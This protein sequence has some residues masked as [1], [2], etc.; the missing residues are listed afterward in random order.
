[1]TRPRNKQIND[2]QVKYSLFD[3]NQQMSGQTSYQITGAEYTRILSESIT[4]T[5]E[6]AD[7]DSG[8]YLISSSIEPFSGAG[9]GAGSQFT[10][11]MPSANGGNPM[12]VTFQA[13]DF[14]TLGGST[15]ITASRV[16]WRINQDLAAYVSLTYAAFAVDGAIQIRAA[17]SSGQY[18][19]GSDEYVRLDD[20]TAGI[21]QALGFGAVTTISAYGTDGPTAGIVT[22]TFNDDGGYVT[23]RTRRG[24]PILTYNSG[25]TTGYH[26]A[27]L[28]L[29]PGGSSVYGK[30]THDSSVPAFN[31][32]FYSRIPARATATSFRSDFTSLGP[33][34]TLRISMNVGTVLYNVDVTFN[35]AP[36]TVQDVLDLINN[37]WYAATD[38]P[39]YGGARYAIV[40][41]G[42][43]PYVFPEAETLY[44]KIDSTTTTVAVAIPAGTYDANDFAALVQAAITAQDPGAGACLTYPIDGQTHV[45][46]IS[47]VTGSASYINL[48]A[49][50]DTVLSV[51][52]ISNGI[53]YGSD[54]A[55]LEGGAE[56]RIVN[57][58]W[59]EY[60]VSDSSITLSDL[61]GTPT[62]KM[63][64]SV[65][66]VTSGFVEKRVGVY[67]VNY[68][69]LT[70]FYPEVMEFGDVPDF[71]DT[72]YEAFNV[73]DGLI[74]ELR[75]VGP[76]LVKGGVRN[77]G[78]YPKLGSD[79]RLPL[80]FFPSLVQSVNADTV[81]L[82]SHTVNSGSLSPRISVPHRL[83]GDTLGATL[84]QE[85]MA[86]PP[87][88]ST[89]AYRNYVLSLGA[90]AS[91]VM[92]TMNARLAGASIE[93]DSATHPS[94]TT[95]LGEDEWGYYYKAAGSGSF[96]AWDPVLTLKRD[97]GGVITW[98]L[99]TNGTALSGNTGPL[100]FTDVNY[101]PT[102][103][104]VF[105]MSGNIPAN[106]D[107]TPR[108]G[109]LAAEPYDPDYSLFRSLN[110]RVHVT[111]GDGVNTFGDFNGPTALDKAVAF[112]GSR[113][114]HIFLKAGDYTPFDVIELTP[115]V[116]IEGESRDT[117]TIYTPTSGADTLK[118]DAGSVRLKNLTVY[119]SG[120]FALAAYAGTNDV[121]VEDC[122]LV[123]VGLEGVSG[124][125]QF[126]RTIFEPEGS[127]AG[128]H[129]VSVIGAMAN[130]LQF[131]ECH[132]N[133]GSAYNSNPVF[134]K[135]PAAGKTTVEGLH[136]FK[137]R[138]TLS[139]S[140]LS[141]SY[142]GGNTGVLDLDPNGLD[143]RGG[144]VGMTIND[145]TF[146]DCVVSA[147][148]SNIAGR[149]NV[150]IHLIPT[151]NGHTPAVS[152]PWLQVNSV[153][154]IRTDFRWLP[155]PA[156]TVNPFSIAFSTDTGVTVNL[157]GCTFNRDVTTTYSSS[158]I[159]G[160]ATPGM[161]YGFPLGI[162]DS[163]WG[164]FSI[165][166]DRISVKD[167]TFK[168]LIHT[169]TTGDL[170]LYYGKTLELENVTCRDYDL[171]NSSGTSPS[172]R[173][174]LSSNPSVRGTGSVRNLT[175]Y[176]KSAS[177]SNQ[178]AS[179]AF[180]Q[181][182]AVGVTFDNV[183]VVD[184]QTTAPSSSTVGI[185]L[186]QYS[187]FSHVN[188]FYINGCDIG[189]GIFV[190]PTLS[191]PVKVTNC[192]II[193]TTFQGIHLL[194]PNGNSTYNVENCIVDDTDWAG[195]D[196]EYY[197]GDQ[198]FTIVGNRVNANAIADIQ[199]SQVVGSPNSYPTCTVT[200]NYCRG[201][202]TIRASKFSGGSDAQLSA[203]PTVR[204]TTT[205]YIGL[206]TDLSG[207]IFTYSSGQPLLWNRGVLITP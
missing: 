150:L 87:T 4:G 50:S 147:E 110:A 169:S 121:L 12:T 131:E 57:P 158:G 149:A 143:A 31:V 102:L 193:N 36:T 119:G 196:V 94:V 115:D 202:G 54:L 16:A 68:D 130:V 43:E 41:T 180:I 27:L 32:D 92:A 127:G 139:Y 201:Q 181:D 172:Y 137:C 99:D 133:C 177:T 37:A 73:P 129:C 195:I 161:S 30:I 33:T 144:T 42:P 188:A 151:A 38:T 79:G 69:A 107:D 55:F 197:S 49:N 140:I 132:F 39:N 82:G 145:V 96:T 63:G 56:I 124:M 74:S 205:C 44:M 199:I 113:P 111:C 153:S 20:V 167:M 97:P 81:T 114:A 98:R 179:I 176:G 22:K 60:G 72:L 166:A 194:L 105:P 100:N 146:E 136:F 141:G 173:I 6:G 112:L 9:L 5:A 103:T 134:V 88:A 142:L 104:E 45:R 86:V 95:V 17:D 207:N 3:T 109:N 184:F 157:H 155:T 89:H 154:F 91:Y 189:R 203:V 19:V 191:N 171:A 64:L 168:R 204:G 93:P 34:D 152:G 122:K 77:D 35:P 126:K 85:S 10:V 148:N 13:S 192:Q 47:A 138:F 106:G 90:G 70:L 175:M 164:L 67:N 101:S 186:G 24:L 14:V 128:N 178:W 25:V 62:A 29:L 198:E 46:I 65:E 190:S 162:T 23:L 61:S 182:D 21:L 200:G 48:Y 18:T 71:I 52:G 28:P 58:A 66:A 156:S 123:N 2:P 75:V 11:I 120:Y 7:T 160:S 59:Y 51:L 40:M 78:L 187:A 108:I 206:E 163:E 53:R 165:S 80:E 125:C 26:G 118:M 174:R 15:V 159:H 84:L 117:T 83:E 183:T 8:P 116:I 135:S 170:N 76:D 1:M 185:K